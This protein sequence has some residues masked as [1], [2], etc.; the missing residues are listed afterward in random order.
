MRTDYPPHW[1]PGQLLDL[2]KFT[3]GTARATLLGEAYDPEKANAVHFASLHDAQQ[4]VSVWYLPAAAREKH[5]Q[6]T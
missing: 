3:D 6:E 5:A 1:L 2:Q 4:F